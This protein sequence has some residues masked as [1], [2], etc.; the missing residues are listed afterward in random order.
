M[1]DIQ[2]SV[3]EEY[4]ELFHYTTVSAFESI[5]KSNTF[6]A[7]HYENLNDTSELGRFRA[8]AI[9]YILSIIREYLVPAIEQDE[10][11]AEK[12]TRK[13]G[14]DD[15][16]AQEA[17]THLEAWHQSSFGPRGL[18][19][20]FICSFCAH[21]PGQYEARHG[22]LSQWR[23]YGGNGGI[24]IIL[25]TKSLEKKDAKRTGNI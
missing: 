13:G 19:G 6:W 16:L 14:I 25:D 3:S 22:L 18:P 23:G 24:A 15:V 9:D 10:S 4:P 21:D 17:E 7:T 2:P 5:Y 8:K 20:P 12:A 11:L 1:S